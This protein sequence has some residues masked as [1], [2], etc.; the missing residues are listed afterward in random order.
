M[1]DEQNEQQQKSQDEASAKVNVPE[2]VK[3]FEGESPV[4]DR[5]KF[6]DSMEKGKELATKYGEPD[7]PSLLRKVGSDSVFAQAL[8]TDMV[9]GEETAVKTVLLPDSPQERNITGTMD[10]TVDTPTKVKR[11]GQAQ[12]APESK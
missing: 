11:D 3:T 1:T 7:F 12:N 2:N 5:R 6:L 10:H 8:V 4:A 9:T